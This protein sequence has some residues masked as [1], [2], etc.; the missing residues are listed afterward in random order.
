MRFEQTNLKGAYIIDLE[1]VRD[2]RGFFARSYCAREFARV[3]LPA[4]VAQC[5]VSYNAHKGTVRGVH[6]SVGPYAEAKLVR[7]TRGA[8]WDVMV[9]LRPD[10][11][12]YLEH[13]GVE[14]TAE[15]HRALFIP[16]GFG[17]GF[18]TLV[19]DTEVY[20]QMS[21]FYTPEAQRGYRYDDPAFG[22]KWPLE[23]TVVSDKDANAP[24]LGDQR[25]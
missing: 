11:T 6:Y 13:L 12:T 4:V 9:D 18:Q 22:I 17:H 15:N 7:C 24:C 23:V 16:A 3:G 20:Y 21:E 1:P 5:N 10:S 25:P 2:N 14:L 8:V 19:D